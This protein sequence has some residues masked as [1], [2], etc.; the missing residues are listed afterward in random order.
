VLDEL[1]VCYWCERDLRWD[2]TV[3]R[4]RHVETNSLL[5]AGGIPAD[6]DGGAGPPTGGREASG[7]AAGGDRR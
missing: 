4:W 2:R 5:C 3:D 6:I 1:V 7:R